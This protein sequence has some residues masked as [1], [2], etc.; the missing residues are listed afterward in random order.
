MHFISV[1]FPAPFSPNR[2]TIWPCGSVKD[3]SSTAFVIPYF[4]LTPFNSIIWHT[5]YYW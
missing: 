2:P 1:V 5:S 4:L 3:T